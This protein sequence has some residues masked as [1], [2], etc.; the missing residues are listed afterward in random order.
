MINLDPKLVTFFLKMG[1]RVKKVHFDQSKLNLQAIYEL[2][3]NKFSLVT[4][5]EHQ[6]TVLDSESNVE[7]ELEDLADIKPYSIISIHGKSHRFIEFVLK[8]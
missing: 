7:Y 2:F 5:E 4:A 6:V 1:D 3:R 8:M